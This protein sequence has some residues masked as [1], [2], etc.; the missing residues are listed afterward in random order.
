MNY[1]PVD[2]SFEGPDQMDFAE[3]PA[4]CIYYRGPYE[5]IATVI[6]VLVEYVKKN[7]IEINGPVRSIFP[8]GSP[9]R[10]ESRRD[11]ITQVAVPVK[12]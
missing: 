4:L 3:T 10:G 6:L 7:G 2:S 12:R 8:E 1:M 11:Y 5:G 9:C